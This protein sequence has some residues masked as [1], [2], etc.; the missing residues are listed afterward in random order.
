MEVTDL[1][2]GLKVCRAI[3]VFQGVGVLSPVLSLQCPKLRHSHHAMAGLGFIR[4]ATICD[5]KHETKKKI[6]QR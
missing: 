1:G 2:F 3:R 4:F 5:N 6:R